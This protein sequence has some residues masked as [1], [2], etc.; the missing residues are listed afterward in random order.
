MRKHCGVVLHIS[1]VRSFLHEAT[2]GA[3]GSRVHAMNVVTEHVQTR[4]AMHHPLCQLLATAAGQHDTAAV[5]A[6]ALRIHTT[7]YIHA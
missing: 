2:V 3:H 6:T 1:L 7:T 4:G 5:E